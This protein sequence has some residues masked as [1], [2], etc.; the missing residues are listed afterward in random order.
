M[1]AAQTALNGRSPVTVTGT[2]FLTGAILVMS[3]NGITLTNVT[4]VS[5]TQI[6]ADVTVDADA[7]VGTRSVLVGFPGTGPR[8][9]FLNGAWGLCAACITVT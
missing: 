5:E 6:T 7:T 4:V 9:G 2:G 8:T 1:A 3:G